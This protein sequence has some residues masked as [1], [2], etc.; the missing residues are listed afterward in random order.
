MFY[1][2][3]FSK[4][5]HEAGSGDVDTITLSAGVQPAFVGDYYSYEF[6][7]EG[8]CATPGA[9]FVLGSGARGLSGSALTS[10]PKVTASA[11]RDFG[12]F[13]VWRNGSTSVFR[14]PAQISS[15]LTSLN[16]GTE[17]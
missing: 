11:K 17:F 7:A 9:S 4:K 15:Q 8:I 6:N 3:K 1:S 2:A 5:D 10:A 12:G 13:V 16:P 14:N